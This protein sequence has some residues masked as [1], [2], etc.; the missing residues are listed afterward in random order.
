MGFWRSFF[1]ACCGAY[2][3]RAALKNS[4]G[5]AIWHIFLLCLFCGIGIGIGNYW[6]LKYRWRAAAADFDDIFGSRIVFSERGMIPEKSPDVSRRQEL[7]YNSLLIYVSPAGPEK[8]YPD[9]TLYDRN[10]IV[11]WC[12]SSLAVFIRQGSDW[13]LVEFDPGLQMESRPEALTF[14]QMKGKLN[15]IAARPLK[16]TWK[17]PEEYRNGIGSRRLF[18]FFRFSYAAGKAAGYFIL[19]LLMVLVLPIFFSVIFK[20]FSRGRGMPFGRIWKSA[21]YAAFPVLAVVSVFPAMQLP[22]TSLYPDL[23]MIG[24]VIYLFLVLRGQ[25]MYPDDPEPEA[26]EGKHE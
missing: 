17:L 19:A 3:L 9:D 2:S 16:G 21:V 5:R 24:W 11:L 12:P 15:E 26:G 14:L 22:G 10:V 4:V 6:L 1:T 18:S 13:R 7:P 25:F 20:A 8:D 23:F